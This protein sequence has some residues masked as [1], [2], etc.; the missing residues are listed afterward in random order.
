MLKKL[1]GFVTPEGPKTPDLISGKVQEIK[2]KK[3][4]ERLPN[5]VQTAISAHANQQR[6]PK[7]FCEQYPCKVEEYL[8]PSQ[9]GEEHIIE[10]EYTITYQYGNTQTNSNT[11]T[12]VFSLVHS[13]NGNKWYLEGNEIK[14]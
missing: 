11:R 4:L 10:T 9:Q 7:E 6:G 2:L 1:L 3:F 5:I 13:S 12:G 14:V 8:R